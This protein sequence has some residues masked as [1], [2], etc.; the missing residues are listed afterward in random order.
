MLLS[1]WLIWDE[2]HGWIGKEKISRLVSLNFAFFF[3][4]QL[5]N[6]DW[7]FLDAVWSHGDPKPFRVV[8]FFCKMVSQNPTWKNLRSKGSMHKT[9]VGFLITSHVCPRR[10]RSVTTRSRCRFLCGR[11]YTSFYE[12][13]D[14]VK[15]ACESKT[16][17]P[18][19]GSGIS[20]WQ[21]DKFGNISFAS[22]NWKHCPIIFLDTGWLAEKL[23]LGL[24]IFSLWF[25]GS[26]AIA[27]HM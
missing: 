1:K 17:L 4:A 12:A 24:L 21:F 19:V 3:V 14:N 2:S 8:V 23:N 13:L 18:F 10:V 6:L 22:I 16:N 15:W 26:F 25:P 9:V 20:L 11:F 7:T 5:E 27:M